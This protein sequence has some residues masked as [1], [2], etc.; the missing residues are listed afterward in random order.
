[1]PS[2]ALEP[3]HGRRTVVYARLH[4]AALRLSTTFDQQNAEAGTQHVARAGLP[5]AGLLVHASEERRHRRRVI[6]HQAYTAVQ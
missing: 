1:M 3:G 4:A 6:K 2:Q 5:A